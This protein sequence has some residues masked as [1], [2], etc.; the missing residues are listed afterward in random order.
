MNQRRENGDFVLC[1]GGSGEG[2]ASLRFL[3]VPF[4]HRA[5]AGGLGHVHVHPYHHHGQFQVSISMLLRG[6]EAGREGYHV[7]RA[8]AVAAPAALTHSCRGTCEPCTTAS[9]PVCLSGWP[10]EVAC[11]V[12]AADRNSCGVPSI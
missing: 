2:S 10:S 8:Q 12:R 3:L 6:E 9:M 4:V 7:H 1:V 11:N 5:A